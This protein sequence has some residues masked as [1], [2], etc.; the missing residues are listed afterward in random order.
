M[1]ENTKQLGTS[2]FTL[3]Q[4]EN[5]QEKFVQTFH[6]VFTVL[7]GTVMHSIHV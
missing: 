3:K 1:V 7:R 4:K 5:M 2:K 6:M